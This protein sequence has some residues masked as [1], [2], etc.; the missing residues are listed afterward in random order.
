MVPLRRLLLRPLPPLQVPGAGEGHGGHALQGLAPGPSP[1]C[2]RALWVQGDVSRAGHTRGPRLTPPHT[3]REHTQ[4]SDQ[5]RVPEQGPVTQLEQ[6]AAPGDE[7]MHVGM[8]LGTAEVTQSP[9]CPLW[10]PIDRGCRGRHLLESLQ[11]EGVVLRRD[12]KGGDGGL[13]TLEG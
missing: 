12:N 4:G 5:P 6:G 13:V 10:S 3:H 11:L 1:E 9:P 2:S 8:D 7:G